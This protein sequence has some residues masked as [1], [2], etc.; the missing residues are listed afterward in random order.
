MSKLA[1]GVATVTS[2][3]LC[4]CTTEL[5]YSKWTPGDP[6]PATALR[7]SLPDSKLTLSAL[8][9]AAGSTP[10]SNCKTGTVD[11]DWAA[12]FGQVALSSAMS[13]PP[14]TEPI[15][16]AKPDDG[17]N[18]HMSTTGISGTAVT[19]QDTLYS[20]VTVKYTNNAATAVA[21]AASGATAGFGVAGPY[22]AAAGFVLGAAGSIAS[23]RSLIAPG[24]TPTLKDYL[25]EKQPVDLSNPASAG[26]KPALYLPAV[27]GVA[28]SRPIAPTSELT[29]VSVSK[30]SCWRAL[31]N[32]SHIGDAI[33]FALNGV[34]EPTGPRAPLDG[35]GWLYRLVAADAD[36]LAQ[37][38]GAVLTTAYFADSKP[39][40]DFPYPVCRKV[41]VEI[42][43]WKALSDA[44]AIAPAKPEPKVVA[45]DA[46]VAD[47]LYVNA[48]KVTKGSVIN[49]RQDCGANVT[50]TPDASGAAVLNATVTATEGIYKAE[51]AWASAQ[52]K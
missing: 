9:A 17:H 45:F 29:A 50:T 21:A 46:V 13:P 12:C 28:D 52:K 30:D 32:S 15:Y 49:F 38:K 24:G 25:C 10:K 40:Q 43:W 4:G 35:D 44:I 39:R 7:F 18:L 16:L 6:V 14:A 37:P 42:T 36:Q 22:G 3:A 47:P 11:A 2:L 23:D 5:Q 34:A 19:G 1:S 20:V 26:L 51:Q 33:P 41:K 8:G 48:A 31:P 27:I